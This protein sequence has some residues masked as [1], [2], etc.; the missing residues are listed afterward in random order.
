[1][2]ALAGVPAEIKTKLQRLFALNQQ[3]AAAACVEA[4]ATSPSLVVSHGDVLKGKAVTVQ[5]ASGEPGATIPEAFTAEAGTPAATPRRSKEL[6]AA[7]VA[8]GRAAASSGESDASGRAAAS[9]GAG[10]EAD[11]ATNDELADRPADGAEGDVD[12]TEAL[13]LICF[14]GQRDAVLLECGHGGMCYA[15]AWRCFKKKKRECP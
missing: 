13:C 4:C 10:S 1:M 8:S 7:A 15:C 5:L 14:E 6:E 9:S 12:G 3:L 11:G 2:W